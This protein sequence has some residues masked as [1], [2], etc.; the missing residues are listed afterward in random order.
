M[1][2]INQLNTLVKQWL[3]LGQ[4]HTCS[5]ADSFTRIVIRKRDN[6]NELNVTNNRGRVLLTIGIVNNEVGFV[7]GCVEKDEAQ[8]I[9]LTIWAIETAL[10]NY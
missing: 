1:H 9:S 7:T 4:V 10:E 6:P 2:R 5:K 3:E 8:M